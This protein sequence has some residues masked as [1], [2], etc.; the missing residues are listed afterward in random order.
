[1]ICLGILWNGMQKHIYEALND[2]NEYGKVNEA[3]TLHLDGEYELFVRTIYAQDEIA[4]WKVDKKVETMF[5]CSDSRD[6]TIFIA[7]IDTKEKEYH[8]YKKRDVFINLENMKINLREKYSKV[9]KHYFFD[10]VMHVTDDENEY[11]ADSK[12][13]AAF[14]E[15]GIDFTPIDLEKKEEKTKVKELKYE[16]K[17]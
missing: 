16:F 7:N 14:I 3:F 11:V 15:K 17:E 9:V 12:V 8:P 5:Q 1:M 2:I 10:N 4:E 13:V 6:V